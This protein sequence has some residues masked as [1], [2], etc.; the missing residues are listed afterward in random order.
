M[1]APVFSTLVTGV[2]FNPWWTIPASIVRERGGRFAASQSVIDQPFV[3]PPS[4]SSSAP[5]M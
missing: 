1:T 5:V 3:N 4:T 2:T